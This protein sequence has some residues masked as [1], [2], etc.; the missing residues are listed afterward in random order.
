MPADVV[1]VSITAGCS[2][3]NRPWL[4]VNSGVY[5]LETDAGMG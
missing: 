1:V 5:R 3:V 2:Q 4:Y